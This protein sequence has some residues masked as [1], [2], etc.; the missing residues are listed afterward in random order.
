MFLQ[1]VQDERY[2]NHQDLVG[3][4]RENQLDC[5]VHENVPHFLM[6]WELGKH[7]PQSWVLFIIQDSQKGLLLRASSARKAEQAA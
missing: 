5:S 1:A 6:L 4:K 3:E 2:Q 7:K